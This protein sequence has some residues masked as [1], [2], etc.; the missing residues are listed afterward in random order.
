MK[1]VTKQWIG[2]AEYDL[3][4]ARAMLE[5]K[6]YRYVV[7]C[8]QQSLEKALKALIA[9]ETEQMPPRIHNLRRL[10]QTLHLDV[11]GQTDSF[12]GYLSQYYID[13][14]YDAH[15]NE[16]CSAVSPEKARETVQQTEGLLK[17]LLSRLP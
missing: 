11:D 8:C 13:S 14:R 12:F 1:V 17:W 16:I 6:R 3:E 7:F 2:H 5:T 15:P 4:T 9:E 10:A